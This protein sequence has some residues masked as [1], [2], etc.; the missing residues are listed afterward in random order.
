MTK[1]KKIECPECKKI[2]T[3]IRDWQKYCINSCRVKAYW[4]RKFGKPLKKECD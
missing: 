3:P 4:R 2:F 1:S